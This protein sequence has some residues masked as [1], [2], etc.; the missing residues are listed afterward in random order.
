M[1]HHCPLCQTELVERH[2]THVCPRNDIGDCR[3]DAI[4]LLNQQSESINAMVAHYPDT[5]PSQAS[6]RVL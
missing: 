5:I 3:Y 1:K 6:E 4:E 2:Q